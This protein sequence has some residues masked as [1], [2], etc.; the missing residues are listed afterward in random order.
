MTISEIAKTHGG[1]RFR[2]QSDVS[3]AYRFD[4]DGAL[5]YD[6]LTGEEDEAIKCDYLA[7]DDWEFVPETMGFV[8]AV[9]KL[10]SKA[11]HDTQATQ[12]RRECFKWVVRRQ[13]DS[14][15]PL[16]LST[17]GLYGGNWTPSVDDVLATDWIV[18]SAS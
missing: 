6:P 10:K 5:A 14:Y 13:G 1:R 9:K 18:E 11:E 4:T 15:A 3:C 16:Y 2:R 7:A 12:I 8:E 17:D